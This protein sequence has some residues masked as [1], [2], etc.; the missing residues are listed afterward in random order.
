MIMAGTAMPAM[1]AMP[2]GAPTKV[3]SCQ[4]IFFLRDQGFL[5]QNVQPDGL[6][7]QGRVNNVYTFA[8]VDVDGN[9]TRINMYL[10]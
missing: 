2:T 8:S 9:W 4:R 10:R 6:P 3:P 7:I 1:S 5:P